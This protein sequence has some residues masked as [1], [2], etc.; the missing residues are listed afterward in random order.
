[1]AGVLNVLGD[2]KVTMQLS[3]ETPAEINIPSEKKKAPRIH[4]H[5]LCCECLPTFCKLYIINVLNYLLLI[6]LV[7]YFTLLNSLENG[8]LLRFTKGDDDG[9]PGLNC[10]FFLTSM[11]D[12][13][14]G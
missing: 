10:I 9:E 5:Y 6:L 12:W 13:L 2:V 14:R 1:M 8:L 11:S 4:K 7:L 3:D